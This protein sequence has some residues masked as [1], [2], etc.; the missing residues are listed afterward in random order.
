MNA[1]I[2][3]WWHSNI[4]ATPF[5][6]NLKKQTMAFANVD[7]RNRTH[8]EILPLRVEVKPHVVKWCASFSPNCF[9][10]S[11]AVFS[12]DNK[13]ERE[14]SAIS[15][16]RFTLADNTCGCPLINNI[17]LDCS[18]SMYTNCTFDS[19]IGLS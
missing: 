1:N 19:S 11:V 6:W 10:Q 14:T 18:D 5:T 15:D 3:V 7:Q 4:Q 13:G 2:I 9:C 12:W 16:A 17:Y 8:L